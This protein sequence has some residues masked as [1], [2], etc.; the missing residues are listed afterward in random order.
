LEESVP[1]SRERILALVVAQPGL[2]LRELPRRLGLSLRS[3]RYHL[4]ALEEERL[5]VPHRS[6][7]Y[8]RWFR[9]GNLSSQDH[10]LISAL[11]V[12]SQ[13]TILS[14]LLLEGPMRFGSLDKA[15]ALSS[16][17]LVQSL[18]RLSAEG[19]VELGDDRHYRLRDPGAV[20]MRLALYRLRFPDLMADAA[21][22]IFDDML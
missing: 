3:V 17:T 8:E 15:T 5:V 14:H 1:T 20:E 16:A 13:R 4:E 11:R 18:G 12:G 22:E 10:A 21:R 2:H 7:R 9:V 19:L 6:G